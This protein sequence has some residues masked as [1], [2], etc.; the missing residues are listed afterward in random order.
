MNRF[1][2]LMSKKKKKLFNTVR[3]RNCGNLDP[4]MATVFSKQN[5]L[6]LVNLHIFLIIKIKIVFIKKKKKIK[7]VIS[8]INFYR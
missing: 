1:T 8:G 5:L 4:F 2:A 7:I 6:V 3:R